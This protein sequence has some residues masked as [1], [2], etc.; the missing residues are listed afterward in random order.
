MYL[1][2]GF[3]QKTEALTDQFPKSL[4]GAKFALLRFLCG[5]SGRL[6][7]IDPPDFY[8]IIYAGDNYEKR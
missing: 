6:V 8:A 4:E 1:T 3:I 2:D 7:S 5:K